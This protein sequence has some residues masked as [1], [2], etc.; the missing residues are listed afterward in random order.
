M[1]LGIEKIIS[2]S[3]NDLKTLISKYLIFSYFFIISNASG[4]CKTGF[5]GL[6]LPLG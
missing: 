4:I 3:P 6:V 1:N 5:G 2:I